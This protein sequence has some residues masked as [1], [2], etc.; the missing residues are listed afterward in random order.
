MS[1]NGGY[2]IIDFK[3]VNLTFE[4]S[5]TI[6]GIYEAIESNYGKRVVFS[7][8][9]IDG[10]ESEDIS[11]DVVTTLIDPS[12]GRIAYDAGGYDYTISV[13]DDDSVALTK[14]VRVPHLGDITFASDFGKFSIGSGG[15]IVDIYDDSL[16]PILDLLA[17]TGIISSY[18]RE[19]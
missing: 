13:F 9:S 15:W 7:G 10:V 14:I 12:T 4:G 19:S 17:E 16:V 2:K 11:V 6:D 5:V 18:T 3:G 8:F 1:L